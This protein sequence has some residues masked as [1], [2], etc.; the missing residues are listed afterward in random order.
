M[1]AAALDFG[2]VRIGLAVADELG[3]LAHPRPHLNGADL[4]GAF[5][6][7]EALVEAEGIELFVVGLPRSLDGKEGPAAKRARVFA[8][9]LK[10]RTKAR[11]VLVDEW[12]STKEATQRLR[13][14]GLDS[15]AQRSRV[16]SAAAAVL[17]QS[18]LD[19]GQASG[20]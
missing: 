7:L 16:D 19:R 3:L 12:L 20:P 18:Y 17:L 4:E 11:V 13:E 14:Q 1:R 5:K 15:R 10:G 2:T 6:Q 8:K 9:R